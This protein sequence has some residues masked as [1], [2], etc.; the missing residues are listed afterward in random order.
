MAPHWNQVPAATGT[1]RIATDAFAEGTQSMLF[2][3]AA[4]P[5]GTD[6]YLLLGGGGLDAGA[7]GGGTLSARMS[8]YVW[9]DYDPAQTG[10]GV[11]QLLGLRPS[12]ELG[13]EDK[14][15]YAGI[16]LGGNVTTV[17]YAEIRTYNDASPGALTGSQKVA[18]GVDLRGGFHHVVIEAAFS[19]SAEK[20]GRLVVYVDGLKR[21]DV[22]SLTTWAA[23]S[24]RSFVAWIG[25]K[26]LEETPALSS[27]FD[28]VE[29]RTP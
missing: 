3:S 27:R 28:N 24:N 10:A 20:K 2:T 13:G 23:P 15:E 19:T 14:L 4:T 11:R 17:P 5:A 8:A 9:L 7:N 21:V 6:N 25:A 18:L 26:A 16:T 1:L 29:V 12:S 22:K